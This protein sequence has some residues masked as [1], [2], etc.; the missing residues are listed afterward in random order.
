MITLP[1]GFY[2]IDF[3]NE[4]DSIS[5]DGDFQDWD[6]VIEYDD[7]VADQLDNPDI[8]LV[9]CKIA[10]NDNTLFFYIRVITS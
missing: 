6:E 2:L 4:T 8:N 10:K 7:T 9:N 1:L 5:I 3:Q